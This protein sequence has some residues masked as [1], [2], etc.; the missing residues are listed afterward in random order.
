MRAE[1]PRDQGVNAYAA[2]Y[3]KCD[4]QHLNRIYDGYRGQR[5]FTQFGDKNAVHNIVQRADGHG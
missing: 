5:I 1:P 4:D 3:G 2:S